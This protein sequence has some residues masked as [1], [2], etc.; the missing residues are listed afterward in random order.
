MP[1][2]VAGEDVELAVDALEAAAESTVAAGG[3]ASG[4]A[5]APAAMRT[6]ASV[7]IGASAVRVGR[8][9]VQYMMGLLLPLA[10]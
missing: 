8:W 2:A 5:H 6:A 1:D 7:A 3:D 4:F 10:L 9:L